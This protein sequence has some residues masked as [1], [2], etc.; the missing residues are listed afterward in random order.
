MNWTTKLAPELV[1]K[2]DQIDQKIAKRLQEVREI[3]LSN[4]AKVRI[5]C[6]KVI[7]CPQLVMEMMI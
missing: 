3:A 4:Q 2:I 7:F 5:M 6:R 1:E